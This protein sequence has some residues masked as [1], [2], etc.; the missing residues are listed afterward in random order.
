MVTLKSPPC[1][2][3]D[4]CEK[5]SYKLVFTFGF[6]TNVTK[7]KYIITKLIVTLRYQKLN[8][9]VK[10]FIEGKKWQPG[11]NSRYPDFYPNLKLLKKSEL[12][13]FSHFG[14][15]SPPNITEQALTNYK[16]YGYPKISKT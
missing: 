1:K 14:F 11:W 4:I 9:C 10:T 7:Q 13:W 6:G 8:H 12:N 3:V 16:N 15:W 5:K 2:T